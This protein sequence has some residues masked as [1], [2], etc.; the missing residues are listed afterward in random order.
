MT[1][2]EKKKIQAEL[3]AV[4]SA[5]LNLEFRIE[6]S[7]ENIERMKEHIKIQEDKEKELSDKLK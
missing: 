6:E 1:P 5:R 7:L 4:Y 2:L 3:A